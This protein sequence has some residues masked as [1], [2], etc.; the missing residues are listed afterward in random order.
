VDPLE[1][2]FSGDEAESLRRY[3]VDHPN[4]SR[5]V[6]LLRVWDEAHPVVLT[7]GPFQPGEPGE[8]P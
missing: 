5:A 3:T 4:D 1:Y 8:I 7:T 2:P 6:A